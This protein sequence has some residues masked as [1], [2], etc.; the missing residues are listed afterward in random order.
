MEIIF[1]MFGWMFI[2]ICIMYFVRYIWDKIC[3]PTKEELKW[4]EQGQYYN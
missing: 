2:I 4:K 3:L 1:F